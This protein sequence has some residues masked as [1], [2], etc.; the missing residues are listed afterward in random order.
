MRNLGPFKIP[1]RNKI[2]IFSYG[3]SLT[4]KDEHFAKNWMQILKVQILRLL[5]F[6]VK[7]G[8]SYII[9]FYCFWKR[10]SLGIHWKKSKIIQRFQRRRLK[11]K[12]YGQ[13]WW[14]TPSDIM[15]RR[16]TTSGTYPRWQIYHNGQTSH[17]GDR[18]TFEVMT[19]RNPWFSSFLV[20]SNTIFKE[21]LIGTT[22]SV[23]SY[24]L[25]DI[26]SI[27]RCC[28]DVATYKQKVHNGKIEIISCHKV[29]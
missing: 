16:V 17:G 18:K 24:Q 20:S 25:T 2:A 3:A 29:S 8:I 26:Y 19:K 7:N 27:C 21:I 22:S 12:S 23:I 28:W 6:Y 14:R 5:H 1:L 13:R 15:T 11:C 9:T 10:F 4:Y